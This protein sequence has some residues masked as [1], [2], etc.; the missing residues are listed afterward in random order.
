MIEQVKALDIRWVYIIAAVSMLWAGIGATFC[1]EMGKHGLDHI[2]WLN[3][4]KPNIPIVIIS[5]SFLIH[6]LKTKN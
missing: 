1:Y 6:A 5:F 3:V 4:L 2:V